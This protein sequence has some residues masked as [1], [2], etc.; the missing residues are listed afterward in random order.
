MELWAARKWGKTP[1][2]FDAL[3]EYD[4]QVMVAYAYHFKDVLNKA[5]TNSKRRR[6]KKDGTMGKA[7][8]NPD[9]VRAVL[10][11]IFELS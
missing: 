8:A 2:E 11:H 3:P 10:P 1:S 9:V 6:R 4:R 5:I 7:Y